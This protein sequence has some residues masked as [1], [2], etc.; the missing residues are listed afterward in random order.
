MALYLITGAAG[1][2]GS[3]IARELV[4]RG[5]RV[6]G[7]DNFETGKPVNIATIHDRIDFREVDILDYR[8]LKEAMAGVDW[9]FHQAALPSVPLSV[10]DPARSHNI[11]INGTFNVLVAAREAKVKRIVYAASSS[12][13]G[14][15]L[16]LPKHEEMVPSPVSPYAVQKLTGEHYMQAFSRVYGLETICLRYFN[17]FG[18]HQDQ[19]SPY[20]GV[21][22]KFI[23]KMLAGES[24]T[25]YGDGEQSRDFTYV[26]NAVEANL[27][28]MA[29]PASAAAGQSYNVGTGRQ[30]SLNAT[31]ETLRQIIGFKGAVNHAAPRVGDVRHSLADIS[32]ARDALQY[33]PQVG[34][35][36]GLR[37]TVGWYKGNCVNPQA[38][39]AV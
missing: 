16:T 21:I 36:E 1:F 8:G 19:S 24:P 15:T 2:I 38:A 39:T 22:A 32:R 30:I 18:P 26:D 3:S 5:D 23:N 29:A 28:A 6:R 35:E 37:R 14:E 20:S 13:Y 7:I 31:F 4:R 27:L 34:F 17:I 12:A 25:I 33:S 9:I 11:N 10:D